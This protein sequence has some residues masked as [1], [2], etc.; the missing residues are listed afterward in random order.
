M[1]G[2]GYCK[3][4]EQV[5]TYNWENDEIVSD[6]IDTIIITSHLDDE[7]HKSHLYLTSVNTNYFRHSSNHYHLMMC[8]PP[9]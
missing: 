4:A 7:I 3:K 6:V 8:I 9:L 5:E 1:T 2:R